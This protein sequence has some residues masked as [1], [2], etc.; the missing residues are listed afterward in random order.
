M[1]SEILILR[2]RPTCMICD[3]ITNS[4]EVDSDPVFGKHNVTFPLTY[5]GRYSDAKLLVCCHVEE[6]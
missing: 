1:V 2:A 5:N 3:I 4:L 6:R